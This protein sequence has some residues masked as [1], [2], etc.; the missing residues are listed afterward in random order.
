MIKKML[1][2]AVLLTCALSSCNER[3]KQ[4]MRVI[5]GEHPEVEALLEVPN[6][7]FDSLQT[8]GLKEE[9]QLFYK[10]NNYHLGWFNEL[11]RQ[12][13]LESL[14]ELKLDGI[15][16]SAKE[17]HKLS[18]YDSSY[19]TLE[20][21]EKIKADFLFSTMYVNTLDN[22]Y[23]GSVRAKRI[24]GDWEITP[25]P[26]NTS[27]TL[28]LALEHKN[29]TLTYDSIRTKQP[30]Y[31]NLRN[32]LSSYYALEKDSL[33][34]FKQAKINDTIPELV[35]LKKHLIFLNQLADSIESNAIYTST[36]AQSIKA[37]Q[38][39][40]KLNATGYSDA[41]TIAAILQD[42]NTLKEKL[43]VN[44][45]RW[46][47]FPREFSNN[48]I[49]VNIPAFSL[50]SV[51]KQDTIQQ[52]KVVVGTSARKTPILS[53]TL[54][55]VVLN[56]TWTVPPTI[57]KNDLVPKATNDLSYFSRLNF[58]IYDGQGKVVSPEN[59][60]ATKGTSYR[61][62]QKGGPG[63][64]LGRVKFMFNNNHAVYLHDTPSQWG[65][66]RNNRNLSSGCVRVQD[67]FDLTAYIF[68]QAEKNLSKEDIDKII[69]SHETKSISV[70]NNPIDVHLLYWTVQIDSSGVITYFKDIY[71]Y[72]DELYKRLQ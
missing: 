71:N 49:L 58:T 19:D 41:K 17:L 38:K 10:N 33:K 65:F 40:K 50:V 63:N 8:S 64:T 3:S 18:D 62:V 7:Q 6:I 47:W 46:R 67:P 13:L 57:K 53:S 9:V 1:L 48:Y 36:T 54:T 61:Y 22:L 60:D 34:P 24:Y 28:L 15:K 45:E 5:Y 44:L 12:Q 72:D 51:S 4:A 30:V 43:I 35:A 66:A 27:A 55:T 26:L 69:A 16:V 68:A 14:N 23:N 25:K 52:H 37:F 56:P 31:T 39:K 2:P 59:W 42:E 21:E 32:K 70:S 11:N 29:I 20:E